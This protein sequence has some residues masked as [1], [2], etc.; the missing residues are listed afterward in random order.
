MFQKAIELQNNGALNE[1]RDIYLKL[2]DVM[3][4]NADIW[5]LL[6]LISQARGEDDNA[7]D[8]FLEAIRFSPKPF[9]MYH[10]N[11]GLSFMALNRKNEAKNALSKAVEIMPDLKEGWNF[12][13]IIEAESKNLSEAVRCFSKALEIDIEYADARANLCFYLNDKDRLI[14]LASSERDIRANFLAGKISFD[15]S[16]KEKYFSRVLS[17]DS[18]HKEALLELAELKKRNGY[19]REALTLFY[20]VL[21]LENNNIKAILEIADIYLCLDDF[22]KSEEFYLKSF[23]IR[24]DLYGAHLNYGIVLY[25]QNRL[26]E[27][28]NEYREAVRLL[29][30]C[31]SKVSYNLALLLKDV[32]EFEEALGLMF[33]AYI[34]DKENKIYQ[35]AITETLY[36]L[37]QKNAELALK[38][39]QNWQTIDEDN[40]FSRRILL[41]ITKENDELND[42]RYAKEL[43]DEFSFTFDET[44]KKL[45]PRIIEEF[46]NL[47]PILKGKILDLGCGTGIVGEAI[48][49]DNLELVGVD[50]SPNMLKIAEGK[51]C[52]NLLIEDDIENF[53]KTHDVSEYDKVLAFDVFSYL[54]NLEKI[55][56][57][58]KNKEVWFSVEKTLD[59]IDRDYYLEASGRYKHSLSYL[60]KIKENLGFNEIYFKDIILRN[61]ANQGVEGYLVKLK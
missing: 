34:E 49:N 5:N 20:K 1:A 38:I 23:E 2:L 19:S 45:N 41:G 32:D 44:I 51:K 25:K 37:Y 57:K 30:K 56:E 55:F 31:E 52:Y 53:L 10:F 48:K 61:E 14:E 35:I 36:E 22:K 15:D 13:G 60:K 46:L 3:P 21:N 59:G 50:I 40:I 29:D 4:C 42:K 43:F 28:L 54:G 7:V 27:A 33:S 26:N 58:L 6:G 9:S 47:N 12:L 11:L 39:A 17:I 8:C 16:E 24:K 18:F